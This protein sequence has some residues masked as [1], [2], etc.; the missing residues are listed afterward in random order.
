MDQTSIYEKNSELLLRVREGDPE[1]EAKLVEENMGLVRKVARRFLDRGTELEDLVQ[2]GTIGMIKAIRSFSLD[3]GTAFSTYAVP[4]IVGEIRRHLRDDGPIK[5]SRIYRRQ[6]V[7][8][9]C[10]QNR[11][12]T[13]EGREAGVAELAERCGIA[14][15]EAV[16]SLD[17]ISPVASL[18]DFVYGEDSVTYEGVL[19]DEE[20]ERESERICDRVALAQSIG[21]M[22]LLW[23]RIVLLRYYRDHTQ[24]QTA[25]LL[26]LT[27][28]KVSREEK[29]IL[30][31][32]RQD[33]S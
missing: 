25:D 11:I 7:S 2:I 27:Q 22:P 20:S 18:S 29:K 14:V 28:V 3:R 8:L 12:R 5:V 26:G 4:L 6:G 33:L 10:E 13:E 31:F 21:R 15:E 30:A 24:Q 23:R 16:I 32:L 9:L 17:A 1:A 19:A